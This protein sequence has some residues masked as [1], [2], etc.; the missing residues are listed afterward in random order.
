MYHF[1]AALHNQVPSSQRGS[2]I[3]VDYKPV[4]WSDIGGLNEVKIK[5]QQVG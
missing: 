5:L 2:D 1:K 4:K 3:L